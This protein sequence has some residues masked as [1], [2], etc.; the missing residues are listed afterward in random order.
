MDVSGLLWH[1]R[2]KV[3]S[4]LKACVYVGTY[5]SNVGVYVS[6]SMYVCTHL[7]T[8]R[9]AHTVTARGVC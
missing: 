8:M 6:A 5:L 1:T 4:W 9:P 7:A 2:S 3:R